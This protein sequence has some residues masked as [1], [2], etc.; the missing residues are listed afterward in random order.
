L[1]RALYEREGDRLCPVGTKFAVEL[2]LRTEGRC[3][4]IP[5]R[6]GLFSAG[7]RLEF[8][9]LRQLKRLADHRYG[10]FSRLFQFC[11]VGASGMVVDLTCYAAFQELFVRTWL[12]ERTAPLVGQPLSL[13]AAAVLA[14]AIALAWNFSLNRRLTFSYAR[15]GSL[16]HQFLSYVLSNLLGISLSLALRLTLPRYFTFF[17]N[18]KLAAAVVG[19]VTATGVSFSMSRWLVFR[20][21]TAE[22]AKPLV[23]EDLDA[24]P[25]GPFGEEQS[26]IG[27]VS[28]VLGPLSS[29]EPGR[30]D[31]DGQG[32]AEVRNDPGAQPS[33]QPLGKSDR[34]LQVGAG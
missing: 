10:N 33:P 5:S 32:K 18:H 16:L 29:L 21:R 12:A 19:I 23:L 24:V 13:T 34:A 11:V 6:A 8:D 2:L 7:L 17:D 1:T 22:P 30:T 3:V 26:G 4:E 25:A 27:P 20:H 31:A 15:H 28:E 14:V 9:D